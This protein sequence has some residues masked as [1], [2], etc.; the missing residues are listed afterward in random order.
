GSR[1]RDRERGRH[2]DSNDVEWNFHWDLLGRPR[3]PPKNKWPGGR[4][5][6]RGGFSPP[7]ASIPRMPL[8]RDVYRRRLESIRNRLPKL[9][10]DG[11]FATPS[12]H[13]FYMTG[14]DFWRSEGLT[15]LLLFSDSEPVV[16]CP[17]FEESRLRGMSAVSKVVTWQ[18]T[19]D[20]FALAAT[21]FPAP[22][23]TL[24]IEPSTAYEDVERLLAPRPGWKP[25]SAGPVIASA[26]MVKT[27]EEIDAM[28]RGVALAPPR[29]HDTVA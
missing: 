17:A 28:R 12:S 15:P 27:P 21:L 25:V 18:E 8:D 13:L 22:A 19:E 5:S 20:P 23:G 16:L 26:R 10:A 7:S 3:R 4:H 29:F 1:Q 9:P 14:I 2:G 11:L 24:S 6:R